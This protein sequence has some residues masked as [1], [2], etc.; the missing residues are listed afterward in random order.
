MAR[1]LIGKEEGEETV[2][3]APNGD[4]EYV[5]TGVSYVA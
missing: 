5:I 2:V 1:A 4:K 3:Q